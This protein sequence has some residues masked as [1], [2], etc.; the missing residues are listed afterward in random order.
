MLPPTRL[1]QSNCL[2][3]ALRESDGV[4]AWRSPKSLLQIALEQA[5]GADGAVAPTVVQRAIDAG[6]DV[7]FAAW[8][9]GRAAASPLL[10]YACATGGLRIW[11]GDAAS[12]LQR[13]PR[14]G[15][16]HAVKCLAWRPAS[17]AAPAVLAACSASAVRLFAWPGPSA[18]F[19]VFESGKEVSF[20]GCAWS[21]DGS[22][23]AVLTSGDLRV[24]AVVEED[25]GDAA[26][27]TAVPLRVTAVR[28]CIAGDGSAIARSKAFEFTA[29]A[30]AAG[31]SFAVGCVRPVSFAAAQADAA[32][33]VVPPTGILSSLM[34]LPRSVVSDQ[35]RATNGKAATQG[36]LRIYSV[37][38]TGG[39]AGRRALSIDAACATSA[40]PSIIAYAPTQRVVAVAS[41]LSGSTLAVELFRLESSSASAAPS[42][43][44]A[45]AAAAGAQSEPRRGVLVHMRSVALDALLRRGGELAAQADAQQRKRLCVRG[46]AFCTKF[47]GFLVAAATPSSAKED[48]AAGGFFF[49]AATKRTYDI[50]L[51]LVALK[52]KPPRSEEEEEEE[53]ENACSSSSP[54]TL[55]GGRGR[56]F[57]AGRSLGGL[58]A[59]L[60]AGML[61]DLRRAAASAAVIEA[62]PSPPLR[63]A[64]GG[65]AA[66]TPVQRASTANGDDA[67]TLR[68][69]L[70]SIESLRLHVDARFD[71]LE[72]RLEGLER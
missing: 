37:R 47:G 2:E 70:A 21:A 5:P 4:V 32:A 39:D 42:G 58:D 63:T 31:S 20:R 9:G 11:A 15:P 33:E 35:L 41:T 6:M 72:H 64:R 8:C 55:V 49:S 68:Q 57:G 50:A 13:A 19:R 26:A 14:D 36:V 10:A 53:E 59:L 45:V 24:I 71:A 22:R 38:D 30:A 40:R 46:L 16:R 66:S 54:I 7:S 61:G 25:G 1:T 62:E 43:A 52:T 48:A 56:E 18:P 28:T 60:P 44:R 27:A 65:V 17:P 51:G 23:L 12:A 3:G 34:A 69:V 67:V 29:I